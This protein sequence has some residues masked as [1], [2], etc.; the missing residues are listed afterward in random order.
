MPHVR[1]GKPLTGD[2]VAK[3]VGLKEAWP[4]GAF[5]I[6]AAY[7]APDGESALLRAFATDN[8][9]DQHYLLAL[10][11]EEGTTLVKLDGATRPFRT[12]AVKRSVAAV[13]VALEE[14]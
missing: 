2:A 5:V 3:L 6:K 12:P 8:G 4:G 7:F 13:A 11:R 14:R 1:V 10:V 9:F